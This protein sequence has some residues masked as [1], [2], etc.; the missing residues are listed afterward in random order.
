MSLH[1]SVLLADIENFYDSLRIDRVV[2]AALDMQ[3]P[4]RPLTLMMIQHSATRGLRCQGSFSLPIC[5][6]RSILAGSRHSNNVANTVVYGV[7]ARLTGA[8]DIPRS[9]PRAWF[10]DISIRIV[11]NRKQVAIATV[12]PKKTAPFE[13]KSRRNKAARA[14]GVGRNCRRART[15]AKPATSPGDG[16]VSNEAAR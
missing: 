13:A 15:R 3:F 16:E 8:T 1:E 7:M 4:A 9:I 11:G 2:T 14:R 6:D 5:S 12:N 10:D